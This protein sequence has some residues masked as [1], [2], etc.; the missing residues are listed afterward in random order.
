MT[1]IVVQDNGQVDVIVSDN[2][3]VAIVTAG[4]SGTS[5][6]AS[7]GS[8]QVQEIDVVGVK[9]DKGDKGDQGQQG[10]Q[11]PPGVSAL[12]PLVFHQDYPASTWIIAHGLNTFPVV[13]VVD[14]ANETVLGD[15]S[16]PDSNTVHLTFGA[17]FSGLAYLL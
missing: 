17:P 2:E 9:G 3:P 14:S 10:T 16:Y 7:S 5:A 15:V 12:N 8:V 4:S 1:E 11:G 13:V 6:V